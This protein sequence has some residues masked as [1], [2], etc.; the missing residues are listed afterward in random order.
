LGSLRAH[1]AKKFPVRQG[2]AFR[3]PPKPKN[4]MVMGLIREVGENICRL[5]FELIVSDYPLKM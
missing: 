2:P 5:R 3:F 4:E 1:P